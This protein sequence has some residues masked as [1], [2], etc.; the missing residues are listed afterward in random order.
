MSSTNSFAI[1]CERVERSRL[2]GEAVE[3]FAGAVELGKLFFF[4]AKF[5]RVRDQGATGAARGVL[6]VEH[7]VVEDVL[8]GALRDIGAVHAAIEQN[9]V[10]AGVVAAELA[11]PGAS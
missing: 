6:D 9:M 8:D 4:G 5:G 7:F 1:F 10:G 2:A 3:D 11:A